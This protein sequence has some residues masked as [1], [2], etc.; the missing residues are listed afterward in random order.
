MSENK[1]V[2][3][4]L[5]ISPE[6]IRS[7][8][9]TFQVTITN[10]GKVGDSFR[11]KANDPDNLCSYSFSSDVVKVEPGAQE[12]IAMTVTFKKPPLIGA[13]KLCTFMITTTKSN[14]ETEVVKGQLECPAQ[15]PFWAPMAGVAVVVVIVAIAIG[16]SAGGSGSNNPTTGTYVSPPAITSTTTPPSPVTTPPAP[17]SATVPPTTTVPPL[18]LQPATLSVGLVGQVY[19][20]EIKPTGGKAPYT[21]TV[22]VGTLPSGLNLTGASDRCTI[23]GTPTEYREAT[24][25]VTVR[26]A[27]GSPTG[28]SA[29]FKLTVLPNIVGNWMFTTTVTAAGGACSDEVGSVS[30]RSIKVEQNGLAVVMSGFVG[31]PANQLTGSI[32]VPS[33]IAG[34]G[35]WVISVNGSYSEDGGTTNSTRTLTLNSST[36]MSGDEAWTWSGAG[37]SCP[38]GKA[39]MTVQKASA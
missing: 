8:T 36:T 35:K 1:S 11:L 4:S 7:N 9:G 37:G 33:S 32:S 24:F 22:S 26:D 29:T 13:P 14:K 39:T 28:M 16:L 38:G 17:T 12:K 25:D 20:A 10:N 23:G 2:T 15:I 18:V 19:T 27:S 30:T 31:N 34:S 5:V 3:K 21:F 6:K